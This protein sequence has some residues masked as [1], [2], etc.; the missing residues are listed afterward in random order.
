M[1][2]VPVFYRTEENTWNR[3]MLYTYD[4]KADVSLN[5]SF[6][7]CY[8]LPIG[9]RP[10]EQAG[11]AAVRCITLTP[12]NVFTNEVIMHSTSD[13]YKCIMT[14]FQ[15]MNANGEDVTVFPDIVGYIGDYPAV[16]HALLRTYFQG[17]L[18]PLRFSE[19]GQDRNRRIEVLRKF[20]FRS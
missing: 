15:G 8:L 11:Y 19:I 4:L 12:P 10:E 5:G 14:G 7:G 13:I 18:S 16:T 17:L 3:A 9:I 20:D 1:L 2:P 6:G